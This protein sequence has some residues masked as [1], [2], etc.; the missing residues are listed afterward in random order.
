MDDKVERALH[1]HFGH[2][3]KVVREEKRVEGKTLREKVA[4]DMEAAEA[5]G[6]R[7]GTRYWQEMQQLYASS[8]DPTAVLQVTHPGAPISEALI[9]ALEHF[10]AA[11]PIN[12]TSEPLLAWLQTSPM[13]NQRELIGLLRACTKD[14]VKGK[15]ASDNVLLSLLK[16][17]ASSGLE[18]E[19][20]EEVKCILPLVDPILVRHFMMFKRSGVQVSTYLQCHM[21]VVCLLLDRSDLEAVLANR[22]GWKAVEPQL[23]RLAQCTQLGR[24]LFTSSLAQLEASTYSAAVAAALEELKPNI[25]VENITKYQNMCI[26]AAKDNKDKQGKGNKM[27]KVS[28]CGHLLD[29]MA[30]SPT[31]EWQLHLH[32]TVKQTAL[33][34]GQLK[35]MVYESWAIQ[36]QWLNGGAQEVPLSILRDYITART[37]VGEMLSDKS[38]ESF[39]QMQQLISNNANNILAVDRSFELELVLLKEAEPLLETYIK[40]QVLQIMPSETSTKSIK[41]ARLELETLSQS[42]CCKKAGTAVMSLVEGYIELLAGLGKGICPNSDPAESSPYYAKVLMACEWF[43]KFEH[44]DDKGKPTSQ[45]PT[46]GMK[47]LELHMKDLEVKFANPQLAA[48]LTLADLEVLQ[49]FK[50]KLSEENKQNLATWVSQVLKQGHQGGHVSS[51]MG[52]GTS[53]KRGH[54]KGP[55]KASGSTAQ[56]ASSSGVMKFF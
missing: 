8:V 35:P 11:N 51:H 5:Q 7:L 10:D 22:D 16:F 19:F 54:K 55:Q 46:Y 24:A 1:L 14:A 28:F 2:L 45:K 13:V 52:Q 36:P 39:S 53:G 31:H 47:A 49:T 15:S 20:P 37:L 9:A 50:W 42:D 34:S 33:Q 30:T 43:I 32:A 26:Q 3:P 17:I 6:G 44:K 12:K 41:Q 27:V 29:V 23:C 56:K 40:D 4:A 48:K 21:D 25:T 38:L 18:K